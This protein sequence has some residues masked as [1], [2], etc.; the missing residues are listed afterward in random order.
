MILCTE[1]PNESTKTPLIN[2]SS[3]IAEYKLNI[4]K[5]TVHLYTCKEQSENEI[6]KIPFTIASERQNT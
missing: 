5:S 1:N 2:Q 4:Q 3:K 6:L